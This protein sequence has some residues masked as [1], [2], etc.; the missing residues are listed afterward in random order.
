VNLYFRAIKTL[1]LALFGRRL[2]LLDESVVR[3]RCWPNDLDLNVH[4]NNG[5][6]L[7]LMDL[8][9]TDLV[10]RMRLLRAIYGRGWRPM[11]A[12]VQVRF[13]RGIAPFQ[14]FLLRTRLVGW[15]EKWI[16]F[17]QRFEAGGKDVTVALV[18]AVIQGPAGSVPPRE[19]AALAGLPATESPP[20]PPAVV[21]WQEAEAVS[22][23]SAR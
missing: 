9:R 12:S 2:S 5:R 13:R 23:G 8:G 1:V 6:Y 10:L 22:R 3:F 7:T 17:E 19:L 4:M 21:A 15:D 18:K 16:F 20:L 11:V 14:K